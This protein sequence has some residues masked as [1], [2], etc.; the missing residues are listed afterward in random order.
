MAHEHQ[1]HGMPQPGAGEHLD[2]VCGMTVTE[3]PNAITMDYKDTK[4]YFC[5]PGCRRAFEKDP[6][7]YLKEGPSMH[8]G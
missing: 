1:D 3:G 7:K 4:Y 8:M 2:P 5:S 6:D